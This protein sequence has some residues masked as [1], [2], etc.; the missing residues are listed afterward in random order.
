MGV[1]R[2]APGVVLAA[3]AACWAA[4]PA[5][6]GP[7]ETPGAQP[8]AVAAA[9]APWSF[10]GIAGSALTTKHYRIYTTSSTRTVLTYL[11]A[12]M[13]AAYRNYLALTGLAEPPE[14]SGMVIYV[15]A[16]R[17]Q[18][19]AITR[20]IT[21][22]QA[23]IYLPIRQGGYCYRDVCVFWDMR[24][25]STFAIAA[26]EGL[27]QFL[28]RRL[29]EPLP[30]WAEEGLCVL[31]EGFGMSQSTVRFAPEANSLRVVNLRSLLTGGRWQALPELLATDAA[32]RICRSSALAPEYYGQLWALLMYIRSRADYR[33]GLERMLADA[34]AG[35]LRAALKAP[36]AMG[37]GRAYLRAIAVPAFR[38]YIEP[39]LV[40]FEKRL[41][42][43]AANLARLP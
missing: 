15:L 2:G 1:P 24:N 22:P 33:S 3:A 32:E 28:S 18:W 16:D 43:Y 30:A 9:K 36:P 37:R 26:H 35:R 41:R 11:P 12:F 19:E 10:G 21:G 5:G 7:V 23:G 20:R 31:A 39:D 13:E 17:R 4:C 8:L 42:S 25:F 34:A 6:C 29:A 27:H 38:L 14:A 40:A